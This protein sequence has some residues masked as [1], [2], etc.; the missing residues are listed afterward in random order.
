[1]ERSPQSKLSKHVSIPPPFLQL[2]PIPTHKTITPSHLLLLFC[3]VQ[4]KSTLFPSSHHSSSFGPSQPRTNANHYLSELSVVDIIYLHESSLWP[5]VYPLTSL[6]HSKLLES[7]VLGLSRLDPGD[8]LL[9]NPLLLRLRLSDISPAPSFVK[10]TTHPIRSTK[11]SYFLS[12]TS[13]PRKL[14]ST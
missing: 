11:S 5:T 13:H 1:M 3:F 8:H 7:F 9:L 14:L 10:L 2:W 12:A 6:A 4:R